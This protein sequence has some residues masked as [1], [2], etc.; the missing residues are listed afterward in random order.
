MDHIKCSNKLKEMDKPACWLQSKV[1]K[2]QIEKNA[3][4]LQDA[5]W[6]LKLANASR[7]FFNKR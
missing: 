5:V 4:I 2:Q 3:W 1:S 6:Y 7:K